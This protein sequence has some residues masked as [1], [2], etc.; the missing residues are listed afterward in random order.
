[1]RAAPAVSVRGTGGPLWRAWCAFLPAL[2]LA[3]LVAWG[4][5]H[6]GRPE[7]GALA[8]LALGAALA[9]GLW[10][11]QSRTPALLA[12]DGQH[13]SADGVV[14]TLAVMLDLGPWMLLRLQGT[15]PVTSRWLP[16]SAREAGPAW[17]LLR[18]AAFARRA[19]PPT[20]ILPG[21]ERAPHG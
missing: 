21:A 1:M 7:L 14:G 18:A 12:W 19:Q 8:G 4:L 3:A 2:A 20:G 5:G 10:K 17:H 15:E 6:L 13:W 16:I 11:R 9:M